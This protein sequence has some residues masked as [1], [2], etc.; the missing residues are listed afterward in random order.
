MFTLR[1]H[2]IIYIIDNQI[3]VLFL[4]NLIL[5]FYVF[6]PVSVNPPYLI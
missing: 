3:F 5:R 6:L 2:A 1:V 4:M